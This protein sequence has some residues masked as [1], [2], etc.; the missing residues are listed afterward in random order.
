V[1]A[2]TT[3]RGGVSVFLKTN[4][5]FLR[6]PDGSDG[7]VSAMA[8]AGFHVILCN[9]RDYP[10]ERWATIRE[11]SRQ[12]G[13]ACGPWARTAVDG[14]WNETMLQGLVA[15]ADDWDA[16]LVVNSEKELDYSGDTL[17]RQIADVC[18]DRDYALSM[19]AWP[20]ATVDW[21][22][23]AHVPVLPQIFPAEVEIANDPA[24]CRAQWYTVG[25]RC[26]VFTFGAYHDM[27]PDLFDRLSPYGAYTGD[28]MGG[29]YAAWAP[30]GSCD[31]CQPQPEP[32]PPISEEE[33][34]PVTDQ[35]GRDAVMF[36]VQAASQNWTQDKP[37]GRLTVA[38]RICQAANDDAKWNACRDTI[39]Q[40][41]DEAGVPQ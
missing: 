22:P 19:E 11:R 17:T 35:Q 26:V 7:N 8:A 38:R 10:P 3:D 12:A 20:F 18:G 39:V 24:G 40:A 28:D 34:E 6:N 9:V 41:L 27:T 21:T 4:H 32:E 23:L 16:P 36:A 33:M 29:N 15:I 37:R 2:I 13:V 1:G 25:V 5:L 30:L 14:A 31:P